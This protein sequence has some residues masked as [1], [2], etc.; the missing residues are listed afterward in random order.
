M[1]TLHN[2]PEDLLDEIGG[3]PLP[4]SGFEDELPESEFALSSQLPVIADGR[5]VR[6]DGS[7]V[8]GW[9]A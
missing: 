2:L 9:E 1:Q 4:G 5:F 3:E 7:F 8:T 6:P